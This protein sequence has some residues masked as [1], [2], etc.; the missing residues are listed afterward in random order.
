MNLLKV[1]KKFD[2]N[3][4]VVKPRTGYTKLFSN[5]ALQQEYSKTI[6]KK[7]NFFLQLHNYLV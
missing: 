3:K 7:T 1:V 2:S 4:K 6:I 5:G